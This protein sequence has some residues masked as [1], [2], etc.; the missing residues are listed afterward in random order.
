MTHKLHEFVSS[1][2][3][4]LKVEN[5]PKPA[6][7][8]LKR[9]ISRCSQSTNS[10]PTGLVLPGDSCK[11]L[12]T[13][14][15]NSKVMTCTFCIKWWHS[16]FKEV[17]ATIHTY[18]LK[19]GSLYLSLNQWS[20]PLCPTHSWV[21]HDKESKHLSVLT[22]WPGQESHSACSLF[23]AISISNSPCSLF[24]TMSS[25]SQSQ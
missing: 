18:L 22:V 4:N 20:K 13:M 14:L 24:F 2:T 3:L 21:S 7:N 19:L 9:L 6:H 5:A 17:L 25:S 8:I 15:Y 16:P 10:K 12:V 1:F 11:L 23:K